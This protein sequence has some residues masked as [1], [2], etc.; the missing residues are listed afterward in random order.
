MYT[1]IIIVQ[2]LLL[3]KIS[4][5]YRALYELANSSY[6][7]TFWHVY[8]ATSTITIRRT[9]NVSLAHDPV[10][11]LACGRNVAEAI[12]IFQTN[13]Y[14]I[15]KLFK[16]YRV[17]LGE[18][19]SED[20]TLMRFRHWKD[21]DS[22]IYVHTYGNLSVTYSKNRAHRIA[23]C[24]NHLLQTARKNNWINETR[25]LLVM[26]IDI[27]ANGILTVENF[28]TNFEYDTRDWAVMTA[29]QTNF[30]TTFGL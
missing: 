20:N 24:R 12:P 15:L 29:S 19:D 7:D 28:L 30:T 5:N 4:I 10:I 23:F 3:V 8:Y 6:P 14:S 9:S 11:V 2:F 1:V 21:K 22:K 18:S 16:N 25:F 26:D 17:L 27:N 13:L